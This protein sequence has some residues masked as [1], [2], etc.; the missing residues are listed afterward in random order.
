MPLPTSLLLHIR[1]LRRPLFYQDPQSY[2]SK[3]C[4]MKMTSFCVCHDLSFAVVSDFFS[5]LTSYDGSYLSPVVQSLPFCAL[6]LVTVAQ[7]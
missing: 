5:S 3:G 1:A 7:G 4:P 6:V 2:H